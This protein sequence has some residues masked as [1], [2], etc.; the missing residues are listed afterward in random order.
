MFSG[1]SFGN[2]NILQ[3]QFNNSTVTHPLLTNV[4]KN[5]S[6]L[7][8]PNIFQSSGSGIFS[9][10]VEYKTIGSESKN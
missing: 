2:K 10:K 7:Y 3:K 8:Q 9:N 5:N 1:N 4:T 6:D